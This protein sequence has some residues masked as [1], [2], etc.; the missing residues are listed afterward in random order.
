MKANTINLLE[1]AHNL[2]GGEAYQ[3]SVHYEL[4]SMLLTSFVQDQ[5]YRSSQSIRRCLQVLVEQADAEFAAKAAIYARTEFGMRN[6]THLLAACIAP[7]LS[8][9]PWAKQFYERIVHR[10]DDMGKI[11][12][13]LGQ[14]KSN[15][16]LP[17]ALKKGFA[18][19][20]NKFDT[21]QL[22]KYKNT[23]D[24]VSLT[25]V[26]RLVHPSCTD[27]NKVG[28]QSLIQ[29]N[30]KN[31][32]TWESRLSA[33]GQ[34]ASPGARKQAKAQV[35]RSLLQEKRL[36]Y[37]ALLR[38]LRNIIEQAPEAIEAACQQLTNRYLI[39]K[40]LVLPFRIDTAYHQ[41]V[42]PA[43]PA[44]SHPHIPCRPYR[45]KPPNVPKINQRIPDKI[46]HICLAVLLKKAPEKRLKKLF[47]SIKKFAWD[48]EKIRQS[49][50][51]MQKSYYE[52]REVVQQ[53]LPYE[54]VL[55]TLVHQLV[56][57]KPNS[58][59]ASEAVISQ[60]RL[61]IQ[62][63]LHAGYRF[64]HKKIAQI[65]IGWGQGFSQLFQILTQHLWLVH[66]AKKIVALVQAH[67]KKIKRNPLPF[68]RSCLPEVV[69][70]VAA[71]K[72]TQPIIA[73]KIQAQ[74]IILFN[75][76][77]KR[78]I[79]LWQSYQQQRATYR[80]YIKLYPSWEKQ[81]KQELV[82]YQRTIKRYEKKLAKY[83]QRLA[84]W[85]AQRPA[86]EA[87]IL[88]V[89]E[90][91]EKATE[92][93][94]DN[95]PVFA[96]HTLVALDTSGSMAGQP[97]QIGSLLMAAL[98]HA[99]LNADLMVFDSRADYL[100][101]PHDNILSI[102]KQIPF[103]GW[104]T[105]FH[106]IF[107]KANKAYDR[108]IILSDMQAWKG[109]NTPEEAYRRYCQKYRCQPY[110]YSFDLAGYGSLQFPENRVCALAGF[111]ENIFDIMQVVEM[112]KNA[113]V[114]AIEAVKI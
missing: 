50:P 59:L 53:L 85:K 12:A 64:P 51:K 27:R 79:Q 68:F 77:Q 4:V 61:K 41:L 74:L 83:Q 48:E 99:N 28:L 114:H 92:I 40:S 36:G 31:T 101:V 69:Q 104:G 91:L 46:K 49:A 24:K 67:Q 20:F 102:R 7:R 112:D 30:L 80:Q 33:A 16:A 58:M 23:G 63:A 97:F 9:K 44:P 95:V 65:V 100:Q 1:K 56:T 96:G 35:W 29:G 54:E 75:Q 38:N 19:A 11:L 55:T 17:N 6:I 5:F 2:A 113:L 71:E 110:I 76:E 98:A 22:A 94:L 84:T 106:T 60:F 14:N 34:L 26:L 45:P 10:P 86:K 107:Q 81:Y 82:Q 87:L 66:L 62:H 73:E 72:A 39:K 57:A 90:A 109:Y 111:S 21:Y 18:Q 93:S 105:D 108:I 37:F 89:K 42:H 15:R 52:L 47:D 3:I 78:S 32:D 103:R 88:Q 8:G 13:Q 43:P 70:L 25:D